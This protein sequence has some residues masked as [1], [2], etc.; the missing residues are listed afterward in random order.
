MQ[1]LLVVL[2]M[3]AQFVN[4]I[5]GVAVWGMSVFQ[6]YT[7]NGLWWTLPVALIPVFGQ[8]IWFG[9]KWN[10]VGFLNLY[11]YLILAFAIT[12]GLKYWL[13]ILADQREEKAIEEESVDDEEEED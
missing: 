11:T 9:I 10:A 7:A 5:L 2:F 1:N 13:A 4:Y 8:L 12:F 6:C 3:I